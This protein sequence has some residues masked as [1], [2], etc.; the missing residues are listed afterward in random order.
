[1]T[2]DD[3]RKQEI[4]LN[5][6][7]PILNDNKRNLNEV[8]LFVHYTGFAALSGIIEN[9]EIWFSPVPLMNDIA[10]VNHGKELIIREANPDG[11][12]W[13]SFEPLMNR[14]ADLWNKISD[15]FTHRIGHDRHETFV[16]CWTN[17][18]A[19]YKDETHDQMRY[20][21]LTMWRAYG[22]SGNGAAIVLDP[23]FLLQHR[24][25]SSDVLL[26]KVQYESDAEFLDR[27]EKYL[28]SF[29]LKTLATDEDDLAAFEDQVVGAF[30]E[31]CFYL[32]VTHKHHSFASEKEWR[33]IWNRKP[34]S[35]D[36]AIRSVKSKVASGGLYERFCLQFGNIQDAEVG[37]VFL[38]HALKSIMIGPCE[39]SELKTQAVS[40]LLY[41]NGFHEATV[42]QSVIPFRA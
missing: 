41:N 9:R 10:E 29:V 1:M 39:H 23:Q 4:W 33:L 15:E 19:P 40:S 32:A 27:S 13:S 12:L 5:L 6:L 25:L 30:A 3:P 42:E 2:D 21:D 37:D 20:D 24:L 11:R 18:Q 36:Q 26:A 17:I 7:E 16:S 14:Y 34:W 22:A 31:L 8:G 38:E 35:T 28:S